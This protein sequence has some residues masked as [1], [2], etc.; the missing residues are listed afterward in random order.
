VADGSVR[1]GVEV[2]VRLKLI[3]SSGVKSKAG[4]G[5]TFWVELP[6]GVGA[7]AIVDGSRNS[8]MVDIGSAEFDI[9]GEAT[10]AIRPDARSRFST[11][12]MASSLSPASPP[13]SVASPAS[14]MSAGS[15]AGVR[16]AVMSQ[17]MEQ[18]AFSIGVHDLYFFD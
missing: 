16:S 13:S 6:L 10:P 12:S 15:P 3:P 2:I 1:W 8:G 5:S 14:G 4:E 18:G 17:I 11:A 9:L 7:K